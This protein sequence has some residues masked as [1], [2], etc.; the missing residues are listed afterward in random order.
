MSKTKKGTGQSGGVTV[1]GT[2]GSVG[3]SIV[4]G[5][6]ITVELSPVLDAI[7]AAAPPEVKSVAE[8]KLTEL[9]QEVAMTKAK[10]GRSKAGDG[11]IAKLLDELIGLV[12]AAASAVGSAF[13]TPFLGALVGPATQA[14]LDKFRGK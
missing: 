2:V 1:S 14:V 4:G 5:D 13:A 12:P 3:G 6:Q 9:K 8:A 10:D 7:K 11:R